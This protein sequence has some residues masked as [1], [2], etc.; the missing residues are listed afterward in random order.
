[1]RVL[2]VSAT[3]RMGGAEASLL[4]LLRAIDR[5]SVEPI[6]V[7]PG[8]GS[9]SF[10]GDSLSSCAEELGIEVIN[11]PLIRMRRTMNP[12][13]LAGYMSHCAKMRG[14]VAEIVRKREIHVVHA[15][16]VTAALQ[17]D[18]GAFICHLRDLSI[19][20]LAARNIASRAATFIATSEAVA[21]HA[22]TWTGG[23]VVRIANGVDTDRF[24]PGVRGQ[25]G[26]NPYL[27][28]I[29]N[30]VPWKRHFMFLESLAEVRSHMPMVKGVIAGTD[31]FGDHREHVMY[32]RN[33]ADDLGL[34]Y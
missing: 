29:G 6:L 4:T 17:S 9:E 12:V 32:L 22:R 23:E 18:G 15:N 16:S 3:D 24:A 5:D 8:K 2:Y 28:M 10:K 30:L 11:L 25:V 20:T 26:R 7:C 21:E 19:P 14:E 33:L 34:H 1:M 13:T 31:L 27:L